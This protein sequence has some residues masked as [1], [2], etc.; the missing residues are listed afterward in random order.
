M[1]FKRLSGD[2]MITSH[3]IENVV[4]EETKDRK[5]YLIYQR[6]NTTFLESSTDAPKV[7]LMQTTRRIRQFSS[8]KEPKVQ[9]NKLRICLKLI[10]K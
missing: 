8:G 3:N 2:E 9:F 5:F 10:K 4:A 6:S 1:D 7:Q